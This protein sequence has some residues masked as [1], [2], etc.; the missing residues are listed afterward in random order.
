MYCHGV[1]FAYRFYTIQ[2]IDY[3]ILISVQGILTAS[4]SVDLTD[5]TQVIFV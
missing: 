1:K 2:Y 3:L 4:D 5:G